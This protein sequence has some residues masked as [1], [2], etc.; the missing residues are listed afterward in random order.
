[1]YLYELDQYLFCSHVD[2]RV[3]NIY[4]KNGRIQLVHEEDGPQIL[5]HRE[6][7]RY[8]IDYEDIELIDSTLKAFKWNSSSLLAAAGEMDKMVREGRSILIPNDPEEAKKSIDGIKNN[9]NISKP[10]VF[11]LFRDYWNWA[12][13]FSEG[14]LKPTP[15]YRFIH[16]TFDKIIKLLHEHGGIQA[17]SSGKLPKNPA[18]IKECNYKL[19]M[20]LASI[21]ELGYNQQKQSVNK[22]TITLERLCK[23]N[24]NKNARDCEYYIKAFNKVLP[25]YQISTALRLAHFFAQIIHESGNL[26]FKE[27]NLNY[28]AQALRRVFPKYFRDDKIANEYARKPE[29]IANRVYCSRMGNRDESSGDGWKFRGRG[30][31]QLTGQSNYRACGDALKLDLL[32]NPDLLCQNSEVIVRSACW[33]W[34]SR[35]LNK[36]ADAD[37]VMAITRKINGGVNGLEDRKSNLLAAKGVLGC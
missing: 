25:S 24:K 29:K 4:F 28:S 3:G 18:A 21:P 33:F 6:V 34:A 2:E 16:N 26:H 7:Y 37:D 13:N 11:E 1:M 9:K 5:I 17:Q 20:F 19:G 12:W 27:E 31:I 36:L 14:D 23:I 15:I 22:E 30:L 35:D 32:K 8:V 10:Y